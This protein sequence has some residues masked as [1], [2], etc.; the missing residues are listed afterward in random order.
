MAEVK[1]TITA[2]DKATTTIA[3]IKRML[4][5]LDK[6]FNRS[7]FTA[8]SMGNPAQWKLLSFIFF[9]CPNNPVGYYHG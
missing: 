2:E 8:A 6:T 4:E 7:E 9:A 1:I 5:E 3:K